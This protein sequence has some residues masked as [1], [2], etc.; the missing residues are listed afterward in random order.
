MITRLT[1]KVLNSDSAKTLL[2]PTEMM[3]AINI[4]L[5]G[6]DESDAGIV[7]HSK[8]NSIVAL[9]ED[10]TQYSEGKNT[11]I[12]TV[13]D[14][15]LG[16]IFFFVHNDAG[17][18][19]IYAYSTKT[20]THRLIF[21]G[22]I[23]NF[24][25]NGFVKG[26]LVRIK[27][28]LQDEEVTIFDP[29]TDFPGGGPIFETEET[30]T[31][32]KFFYYE[33]DFSLLAETA[34]IC[35]ANQ[36]LQD[37]EF[38]IWDGTNVPIGI[39]ATIEISNDITPHLGAFYPEVGDVVS[40]LNSEAFENPTAYN[41]LEFDLSN[42]VGETSTNADLQLQF[43]EY[44]DIDSYVKSWIRNGAFQ[45]NLHPDASTDPNTSIKVTLSV[46][47]TETQD[48]GVA[49]IQSF[50]SADQENGSDT[51]WPIGIAGVPLE[52]SG[53]RPAPENV[54]T[55]TGDDLLPV[56]TGDIDSGQ[57]RPKAF[58]HETISE[59]VRVV[60]AFYSQSSG[61]VGG[62]IISDLLGGGVFFSDVGSSYHDQA[63]LVYSASDGS[64]LMG[65]RIVKARITI[66]FSQTALW[67]EYRN[68]WQLVYDSQQQSV[69]EDEAARSSGE[70]SGLCDGFS[71]P[72]CAGWAGDSSLGPLEGYFAALES[73]QF[74]ND[75]YECSIVVDNPFP[76]GNVQINLPD[77]NPGFVVVYN[78]DT[79]S[80]Q[81]PINQQG[82]EPLNTLPDLEA[83]LNGDIVPDPDIY[84]TG[85]YD[86]LIPLQVSGPGYLHRSNF[87]FAVL[88]STAFGTNATLSNIV[89]AASESFADESGEMFLS[90]MTDG[91]PQIINKASTSDEGIS[92][93]QG[94]SSI[95][96]YPRPLIARGV[97]L[98]SD[99][100]EGVAAQSI[101][102]SVYNNITKNASTI[103]SWLGTDYPSNYE[104]FMDVVFPYYTLNFTTEYSDTE[105]A[106]GEILEDRKKL[107]FNSFDSCGGS[108]RNIIGALVDTESVVSETST[109]EE[110]ESST[111]DDSPQERQADPENTQ[112]NSAQQAAQ[113]S[114][115]K[116]TKGY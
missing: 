3:D 21:K 45:V 102:E 88:D 76:C 79:L 33:R 65:N 87:G 30:L 46:V 64:T 59:E 50:S 77:F 25:E 63:S 70:R 72:T 23:L 68:A 101:A 96:W 107:C 47:N 28:K 4:H 75:T 105:A 41:T 43:D 1:P 31:V 29:N 73:A 104:N 58:G 61:S 86:F 51:V 95:T 89:D 100:T 56:L 34:K 85:V 16:V 24:E 69:D 97:F 78:D 26:D 106:N 35:S 15:N 42:T 98:D 9:S 110:R 94:G 10:I 17:N 62:S 11:V 90:A 112:P 40:G 32:S 44:S 6:K 99:F 53:G 66:V 103:A 14:E 8:G 2:K 82:G 12:G 81:T 60:D 37:A 39:R 111:E 22:S 18:H 92:F 91:G 67:L 54:F 57:E 52:V 49:A 20:N 5:S 7:K 13:S 36:L 80:V 113:R 27:R 116:T 109:R 108:S 115:T 48:L 55:Y 74:L 38:G 19:G 93:Q 114:K 84:A 83:A 71:Q